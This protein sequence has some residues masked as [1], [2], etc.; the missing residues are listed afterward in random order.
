MEKR[1]LIV[2]RN[3]CLCRRY[4]ELLRVEGV[5]ARYMRRSVFLDILSKESAPRFYISPEWARRYIMSYYGG[6][7]WMRGRGRLRKAMIADLVEQYERL[8]QEHPRVSKDW[9]YMKVVEQPARSFYMSRKRM[10][11]VL[12]RYSGRC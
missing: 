9:L 11:E 7:K 2:E 3:A 5:N 8:M 1:I 10:Q 12:F 6:S 4:E